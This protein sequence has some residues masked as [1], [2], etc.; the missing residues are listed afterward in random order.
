MDKLT[1][2]Q[3]EIYN[4]I[5]EHILDT[6]M[7]PTRMDIANHFGF[8]SPN[9]AEDHLRALER[10]GAIEMLPGTS[11]GIRLMDEAEPG[12]PVI[13]EVAAGYPVL[14]EE[15]I[16]SYCDVPDSMFTP[17]A[18]YFLKV[19]GLSMKDAGIF[20]GDLLAVH[21]T[22]EVRRG[23]IVVARI[24][25]EVTVKRFD[26]KRNKVFLLPENEDFDTIEVDSKS[27]EFAIEGVGV[28]IIRDGV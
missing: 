18:D 25:A 17:S 2:R 3:Q 1:K 4:L 19:K 9:A 24:G 8:R 27:E 13:G 26:K 6:G 14:A 12:I 23:Q 22:T 28:G 20:D 16:H 7:P 15:N 10:K 5:R 21:K 11:R